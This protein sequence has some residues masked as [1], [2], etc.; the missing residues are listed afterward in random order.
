[1]CQLITDGLV[2][3][4]LTVIKLPLVSIIMMVTATLPDDPP[5]P[6]VHGVLPLTLPRHCVE[7]IPL[8]V[9]L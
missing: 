6:A 3:V 4:L 1:M 8:P 5:V 7:V 9:L 2:A